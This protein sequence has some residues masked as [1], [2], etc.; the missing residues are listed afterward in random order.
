[1]NKR[2]DK[3]EKNEWLKKIIYIEE[4]EREKKI[5]KGVDKKKKN[6]RKR[7][8]IK[9]KN[10]ERKKEW[11]LFFKPGEKYLN[12]KLKSVLIK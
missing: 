6:G 8:I 4:R 7:G 11:K 10:I 1:M 3:R 5:G 12:R 9:I 2:R